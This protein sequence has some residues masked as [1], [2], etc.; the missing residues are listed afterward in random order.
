[1]SGINHVQIRLQESFIILI[2]LHEAISRLSIY[3]IYF[4]I[5]F[6][7]IDRSQKHI[8]FVNYTIIYLAALNA[9]RRAEHFI[10]QSV[11][12]PE[13]LPTMSREPC[14]YSYLTP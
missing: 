11:L 10:F 8:V 1:M 14:L 3:K 9:F 12:F 13:L 6:F 7:H 4:T 2:S 5:L